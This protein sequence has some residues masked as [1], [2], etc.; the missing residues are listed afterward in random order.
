MKECKHE[1]LYISK[2]DIE[3]AKGVDT[4]VVRCRDCGVAITAFNNDV[5][6]TLNAILKKIR[7]DS[8]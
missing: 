7:R 2:E 6:A 3:G 5:M 8:L 1:R 4:A